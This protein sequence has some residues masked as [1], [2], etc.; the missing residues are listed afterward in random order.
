[1]IYREV[2]PHPDLRGHIKCLWMLDHDYGN[3]L[4]DRERLWADAHTE[5]IFTT[6]S[7]YRQKTGSRTRKL[8]ADIVI[9]P[10]QHQLELLS[11]GR[12]AL[13]AARF[14]PWGFHPLSRISMTELKNTVQGSACILRSGIEPCSTIPT[15]QDALL[16]AMRACPDAKMLS[17]PVA[18][19]IMKTNGAVPIRELLEKHGMHA[20][21]LERAFLAEIGVTAKVLS[22]IVRFN[23]AKRQ[24]ER[25]PEIDLPSLS[26][27]CGYA[28]QSHFTR[29]FREMFAVTPAQFKGRMQEAR[30][31]FREKPPD[32]VFV[33]DNKARAD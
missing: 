11:G 5:L 4:H 3:S 14:W 22:R 21:Q 17:R 15:L 29:N 2:E 31:R 19:G 30:K 7:P 25:N 6:G 23:Y 16:K 32:V 8:P 33:Q 12:T 1:M 26:Y 13:V 18:A 27:E 20:R 24:I 28:D 9:G 10:F